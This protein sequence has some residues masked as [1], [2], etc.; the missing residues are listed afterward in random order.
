MLNQGS[1]KSIMIT[2]NYHAQILFP[3]LWAI[4]AFALIIFFQKIKHVLKVYRVETDFKP[5]SIH[6]YYSDI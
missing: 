3:D 1:A 2:F 4:E 6:N 5:V